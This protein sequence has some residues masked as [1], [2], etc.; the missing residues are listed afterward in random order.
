MRFV[1]I[2]VLSPKGFGRVRLQRL[3]GVSG[4]SLTAFIGDAVEP[5]TEVRFSVVGARRQYL[6]NNRISPGETVG[7]GAAEA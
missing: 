1:P 5:G 7:I 2:E 4:N 6:P 3:R